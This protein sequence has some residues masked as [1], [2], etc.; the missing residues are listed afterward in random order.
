MSRLRRLRRLRCLLRI[1]RLLPPLLRRGTFR[2]HDNVED[3]IG[4][5]RSSTRPI[6]V[7]A[8][9]VFVPWICALDLCLGR[10]AR[11]KQFPHRSKNA[12]APTTSPRR[13][14]MRA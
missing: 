1:C 14:I 2:L 6:L 4:R 3:L 11:G 10:F 7:F 13:M 12:N 5:A 9:L 8:C